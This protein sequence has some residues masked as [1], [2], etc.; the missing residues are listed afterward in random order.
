MM[1]LAWIPYRLPTLV[2]LLQTLVE[3]FYYFSFLFSFSLVAFHGGDAETVF[4]F[5]VICSVSN[6]IFFLSQSHHLCGVLEKITKI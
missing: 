6:F 3:F 1:L 5:L 4:L 2:P